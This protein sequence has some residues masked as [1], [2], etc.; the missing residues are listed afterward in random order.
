MFCHSGGWCD[1]ADGKRGHGW[2]LTSHRE[3]SSQ[4]W[5]S[6]NKCWLPTPKNVFLIISSSKSTRSSPSCN[7]LL[8]VVRP[9]QNHT[10]PVRLRSPSPSV[11]VSEPGNPP[12]SHPGQ[13]SGSFP[14]P[15]ISLS[16]AQAP[17][18][19]KTPDLVILQAQFPHRS[20][21]VQSQ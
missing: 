7:F 12:P 11:L 13:F 5:K 3:L 9:S 6:G 19:S 20:I 16:H 17:I 8:M 21:G 2:W 10:R 4:P 14:D 15:L 18:A 1:T